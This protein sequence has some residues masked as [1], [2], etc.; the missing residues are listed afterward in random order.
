MNLDLLMI[1]GCKVVEIILNVII[2]VTIHACKL[3]D[4]ID[5]QGSCWQFMTQIVKNTKLFVNWELV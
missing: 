2:Q 4:F 1:D 5:Y 3:Y